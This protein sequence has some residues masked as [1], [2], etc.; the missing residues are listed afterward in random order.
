MKENTNLVW[1]IMLVEILLPIIATI[2]LVLL[3]I[4]V[5]VSYS[6]LIAFLPI[7]IESTLIALMLLIMFL[8]L[9]KDKY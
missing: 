8:P 9:P 2:V 1:L 5:D 3:K 6:W 7:I 4:F